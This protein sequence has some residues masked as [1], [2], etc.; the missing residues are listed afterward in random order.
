VIS[1]R[2]LEVVVVVVVVMFDYKDPDLDSILAEEFNRQ[3]VLFD[4]R[5][6]NGMFVIKT[7]D[8]RI[9]GK[10]IQAREASFTC[11]TADL[12]SIQIGSTVVYEADNY[13]VVGHEEDGLGHTRLEFKSDIEDETYKNQD[14]KTMEIG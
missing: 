8:R 3:F 4:G 5:E 9:D 12:N 7:R 1:R 14:G 11:R 6:I 13:E 2:L 10:K